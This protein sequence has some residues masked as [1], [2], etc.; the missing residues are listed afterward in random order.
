MEKN[1]YLTNLVID[2]MEII[3]ETMMLVS[4]LKAKIHRATI[5]EANLN[6]IGSITIDENLLLESGIRENEKVQIVNINN[7]SR[8][9]TYTIKGKKGEG[10]ICVNGAAARLVNEGD[11]IIII[12]YCQLEEIKAS[13]HIPKVIF[14]N[15]NNTIHSKSSQEVCNA[16]FMN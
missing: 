12:S 1:Q 10:Q 11:K 6:Y 15:D 5:T 13:S 9:E 2:F 14:M 3:K 4:M 16:V 8:F 7:G